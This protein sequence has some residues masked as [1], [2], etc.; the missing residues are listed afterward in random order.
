M[1][2]AYCITD[3]E[4]SHVYFLTRSSP[5]RSSSPLLAGAHGGL[6]HWRVPAMASVND[7][8]DQFSSPKV[9]KVDATEAKNPRCLAAYDPVAPRARTEGKYL[10]S[11]QIHLCPHITNWYMSFHAVVVPLFLFTRWY[12]VVVYAGYDSLLIWCATSLK[13][14]RLRLSALYFYFVKMPEASWFALYFGRRDC[15]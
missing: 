4:V 14:I 6:L 10:P 7:D 13:V 2:D 11:T 9:T 1:L 12:E 15:M 3:P 8:A 5:A